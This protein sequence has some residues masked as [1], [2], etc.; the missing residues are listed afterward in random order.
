VYC[1]GTGYECTPVTQ[2]D[3]NEVPGLCDANAQC[4]YDDD[5]RRYAC[6]CNRG[7]EGNGRQCDR[8]GKLLRQ[9][10]FHNNDCCYKVAY[11]NLTFKLVLKS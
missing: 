4:L 9:I 11:Y 10:H 1:V 7:F 6:R 3:C 2:E 8:V 5:L